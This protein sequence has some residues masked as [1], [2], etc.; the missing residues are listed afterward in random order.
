MGS[1]TIGDSAGAHFSL[2]PK[3]LD[4]A[5]WNNETFSDFIPKL[6]N[7]FDIPQK[8]PGTGFKEDINGSSFYL[9]LLNRNRCNRNDY[10]NLAV[11]GASSRDTM[12]NMLAIARN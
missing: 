6:E 9:K 7:E 4:G 10:Q 8:S 11:N 3:Y 12:P 2:P 5:M 1:I